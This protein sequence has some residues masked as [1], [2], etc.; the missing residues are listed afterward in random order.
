MGSRKQRPWRAE[1]RRHKLDPPFSVR[2][3]HGV[4]RG[5]PCDALTAPV[6]IVIVTT[7]GTASSLA[8]TQLSSIGFEVSKHSICYNFNAYQKS[9]VK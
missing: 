6:I 8:A 2:I 7:L 4:G 3:R 5:G 1:V 9:T